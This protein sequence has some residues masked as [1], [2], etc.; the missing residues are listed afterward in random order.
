MQEIQLIEK[1]LSGDGIAF[2]QLIDKYRAQLFGYLWK[3]S[4]SRYESEE[5][6]Q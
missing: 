3:F 4:N 2:N 5:M 1:C 6:F